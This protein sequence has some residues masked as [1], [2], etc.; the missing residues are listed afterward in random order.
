MQEFETTA[1]AQYED[2]KPEDQDDF[3]SVYA[4]PA[5]VT[6]HSRKQETRKTKRKKLCMLSLKQNEILLGITKVGS[7]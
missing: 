1:E 2:F 4:Q 6:M 3:S 7:D 5:V